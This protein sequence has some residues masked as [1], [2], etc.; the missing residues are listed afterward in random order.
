MICDRGDVVVVPF[1]FSEG[2]GHKRRP[3]LVLSRKSFNRSGHSI[4][5]MI[6]SAAHDPWPG[7]TPVS[8]LRSAG[9]RAECMIRLKIF[10][11][12]NR[13]VLARLGRLSARDSEA[14]RVAVAD[15][16]S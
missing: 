14:A 7:D 11:L 12:D 8:D 4:L 15:V 13:L 3:A 2:P 1:P 16:L 10:T 9:L 5:A 6:T